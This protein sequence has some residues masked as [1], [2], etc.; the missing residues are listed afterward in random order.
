MNKKQENPQMSC[1]FHV[2]FIFGSI[3]SSVHSKSV[4]S[5]LTLRNLLLPTQK[6]VT[7][8]WTLNRAMIA[9][10]IEWLVNHGPQAYSI[11]V[12][13]HQCEAPLKKLR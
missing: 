2:F 11:S 6:G 12:L 8:H 9:I 5:L 4:L 13:L 1:V 3:F 10:F 7:N